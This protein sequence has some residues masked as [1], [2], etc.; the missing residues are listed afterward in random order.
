MKETPK[1]LFHA[2]VAALAAEDWFALAGLCDADSLERLKRMATRSNEA[3]HL[4]ARFA[5][6][7]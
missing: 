5:R 1:D 2:A 7:W 6:R 4:T 3:L